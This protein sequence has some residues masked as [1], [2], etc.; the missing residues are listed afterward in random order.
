VATAEIKKD[1]VENVA[2][3]F[4]MQN[5][6]SQVQSIMQNMSKTTAADVAKLALT[7]VSAMKT[8]VPRL[9]VQAQ[10]QDPVSGWKN[11][12]SKYDLA[13][14]SAKPLGF[15]F[16]YNTDFSP[17]IVKLKNRIIA[18]E[19]A[20]SQELINEIKGMIN[21]QIGLPETA[22]DIRT[23]A[24]GKVFI[25]L[26]I[27]VSI[28]GVPFT[29]STE[30]K[31]TTVTIKK[32]DFGT[33]ENPM[34]DEI[35][36]PAKDTLITVNIPAIDASGT[37]NT[38]STNVKKS[39]EITSL[40]N[41]I[42]DGIQKSLGGIDKMTGKI[43]D[44]VNRIINVENRLFGRLESVLKNPNRFMQPALIAQGQ[45]GFFY[46]SRIYT[47]PTKVAQ[48]T[49]IMFYPT[50]LNAEIVAP[51]FKKYVAVSGAWDADSEKSAKKF[52]S[53][54]MNTVFDGNEYNLQKPF[55]YTVNA[56]VGTVLEII[57]ECL[58]FDGKVA[59]KKYYIEVSE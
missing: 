18:R 11:Y 3:S 26:D 8:D 28:P 12:V 37:S 46:P 45:K 55:E 59:G 14:V 43:E 41:A 53:G 35:I 34:G 51:A 31:T 13:A 42:R 16:L 58:G 27:N 22:G 9:G 23:T 44:I 19:K 48:G 17:A 36:M 57:Y 49:K 56:P 7:V 5:A 21:V 40:F 39:I 38:I 52:N 15:D 32:G 47:H 54:V 6:K 30:A 25:D 20:F 50:S 24:D 1:D 33:I 29:A 4:D 10:W 2:L